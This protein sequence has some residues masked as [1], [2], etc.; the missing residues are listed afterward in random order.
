[1]IHDSDP[2]MHSSWPT[3]FNPLSLP[4]DSLMLVNGDR[5]IDQKF[6]DPNGAV[7]YQ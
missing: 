6:G 2:C 4:M 1:V 7:V 5:W 3:V